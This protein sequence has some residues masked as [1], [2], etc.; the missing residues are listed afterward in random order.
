MK[1]RVRRQEQTALVNVFHL[2]QNLLVQLVVAVRL[3]GDN[4]EGLPLLTPRWAPRP[5]GA[6]QTMGAW[7]A[8][9]ACP[10]LEEG[11]LHGPREGQPRLWFAHGLPFPSLGLATFVDPSSSTWTTR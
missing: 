7:G 1:Q 2:I 4:Q 5:R 11:L 6:K 9:P 8:P 10:A 3:R